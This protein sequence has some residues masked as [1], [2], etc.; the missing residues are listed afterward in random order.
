MNPKD[1]FPFVDLS[2]FLD[3]I[4]GKVDSLHEKIQSEVEKNNP[5]TKVWGETMDYYPAYSYPPSN[6]YITPDK[7]IVFEMALA[8][9]RQE[10]LDLKFVG[11]YMLFSAQL[12]ATQEIEGLRY[13]KKRLKLKPIEEQKFYVPEDKFARDQVSAT[14]KNGL[15]RIVI[16]SQGEVKA[17][18]GV[19][20]KI[21]GEDS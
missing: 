6:V 20:I 8:G 21:K 1:K 17:K 9:F 14:F 15:L 11:D 7:A 5:F 13:L 16:P 18:P 19:S 4:F 2:N 3:E 12:D 10:D